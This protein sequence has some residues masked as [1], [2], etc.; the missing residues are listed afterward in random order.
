MTSVQ[1]YLKRLLGNETVAEYL[2]KF[3][4]PIHEKFAEIAALDFF[5]IK[6]V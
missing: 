6:N 2:R 4:E 1:A 5:K 3:H